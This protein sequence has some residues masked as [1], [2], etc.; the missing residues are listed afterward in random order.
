MR[1]DTERSL[2]LAG[3]VALLFVATL[4][5][6]ELTT[7]AES[8]DAFPWIVSPERA[9]ELIEE[10]D[11]SV[12]DTRGKSRWKR[13]HLPG[14]VRAD[15]E[16]FTPSKKAD[17]GELLADTSRLERRIRRLG[18][19]ADRPVLVVGNPPDNWG[20]DGRIVWM[21]RT[22][23]HERVALVDGGHAAVVE[24]GVGETD[25]SSEPEKGDF[26]VERRETWSAD[27]AAVR[28]VIDGDSGDVVLIDTRSAREYAGATPYGESRGGH[29]PGAKHLHY[30][31]LL[32]DDG[33]LLPAAKIRE[34]L[35]GLGVTA[36]SRVVSYCTGGV[37]SAWLT[38]VLAH[39]G[40]RAANYPGSAWDWSAAPEE[41]HPLV[42][43]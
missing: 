32:T 39:L 37:R 8:G 25:E 19:D 7:A 33:R 16:T 28:K 41:K 1:I 4:G 13:G 15:W 18:V 12:L 40:Y 29:L 38:V 17:R 5:R 22:L 35:A 20:E 14:A 36:D 23:G 42:E 24:A 43:E 3:L 11:A 26:E 10:G 27:R 2:L 9:V 31:D 34:K 6:S 21:L 30:S